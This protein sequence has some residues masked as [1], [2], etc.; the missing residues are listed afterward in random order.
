MG[1]QWSECDSNNCLLNVEKKRWVHQS[2]ERYCIERGSSPKRK[3]YLHEASDSEWLLL[4]YYLAKKEA[5]QRSR[6]SQRLQTN[7]SF[8]FSS[9]E[10]PT[11]N[12][13][14]FSNS[15]RVACLIWGS[16]PKR[17]V[18]R[19]EASDVEWLLLGYYL[20]KK[21][22]LQ[23]SRQWHRLQTKSSFS[24]S[25]ME[26]PPQNTGLFSHSIRVADDWPP[27]TRTTFQGDDVPCDPRTMA[28]ADSEP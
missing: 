18:Y 20:A 17:K 6:Q 4:G 24:F 28:T 23:R 21:E 27:I 12:T 5:L 2:H 9:T 26:T 25:S 8:S 15:I 14:L 1:S 11:Q 10:T 13:G 7:C 19:H 16:S 22:V 3:A